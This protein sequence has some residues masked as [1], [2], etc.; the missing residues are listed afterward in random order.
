[1]Q[2]VDLSHANLDNSILDEADLKDAKINTFVPFLN[3]ADVYCIA[4]SKTNYKY[5]ISGSY[6]NTL[7]L[8]DR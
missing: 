7:K 6:D 1:M 8:W 2:S 4:L 3:E 5:I